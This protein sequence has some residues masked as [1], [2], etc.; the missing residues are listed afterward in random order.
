MSRTVSDGSTEL[1]RFVRWW[2]LHE[3]L[4]GFVLLYPVYAIFMLDRGL[5]P[6]ELSWLFI[7]WSGSAMAFEVPTGVWADRFSRRNLLIVANLIKAAA[8]GIWWLTP[9]FAGFA[10]GFVL[11]ALA[12]ACS[13]GAS[14]AYVHDQIS[15]ARRPELFE[16]VYG[17]GSAFEQAGAVVAL[18]L[19]GALAA[20]GFDLVFL[21]SIVTCVAAALAARMGF[22]EIG[23]ADA[24][25]VS[26][27]DVRPMLFFS[28]LR[29][30][31]R[32]SLATR[33]V[34][35]AIAIIALLG[36]VPEI[37]DEYIGPLLDEPTVFS[38]T[39]IG[40]F[41][42]LLSI[43]GLVG[44][45][46][47]EYWK[48]ATPVS[49]CAGYLL[50]GL[51]LVQSTWFGPWGLIVTLATVFF[52]HGVL[53]VL[54]QGFLQRRIDNTSRATVTSLASLAQSGFA[55]P[56]YGVIGAIAVSQGFSGAFTMA[57]FYTV[58]VGSILLVIATRTRAD[59][60]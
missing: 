24:L 5:S 38:V 1:N 26:E 18:A 20:I 58:A 23:S 43:P 6:L 2:Y 48:S 60:S 22:R 37:L 9:G 39:S 10:A 40:L 57:G 4:Q 36:V 31:A 28:T 25:H 8:F 33:G 15:L 49:M 52:T 12:S 14:E 13:S 35:V 27:P 41:Y 7:I 34:A 42:A 16:R 19:G 30:S 11:W 21:A 45:A 32:V 51:L 47:A 29:E 3:F 44:T 53:S 50:V 46:V 59:P 17:R 54:L 55:L 56:L